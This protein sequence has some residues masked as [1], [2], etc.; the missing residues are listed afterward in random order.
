MNAAPRAVRISALAALLLAAAWLFWP[1]ALGG[2]TVYV[3][4]HGISMQPRFHTGDLAILRAADHY[5]VGD[6]VAYRSVTMKTTVMHRIV[7]MDGDRFVIQGDNNSWLDPDE[8]TPDLVLGKLWLRIPQ[9]GKALGL[10]NSPAALGLIAAAGIGVL[11]VMHKPR[12]RR[13]SRGKPRHRRVYT[14]S[15]RALAR[16]ITFASAGVALLAAA[17]G[18]ILLAMPP[19]QT[20]EKSVTVTQQ[21]RYDYTGT[22]VVG[23]TY[24]TGRIQTGD[25]IY[26]KLTGD[27]TVSLKDTLGGTDL[28]GLSGT[29]RLAVSI[30]APDGWTADVGRGATVPLVDGRT[31]TASAVVQSTAAAELLA[32]HYAEVGS[33]G[34]DATLTVTPQL[35]V[36]GTVAG[37]PFTAKTL[38]GLSF[39]LTA[40]SLRLAGTPGTALNPSVGTPVTVEQ[41]SPRHFTLLE[42][43]ISLSVARLAAAV[44][45]PLALAVVAVAWWIGRARTSDDPA[46]AFLMRNAAR[47]LPV[48]RFT[49]GTT[50]IDVS[51]ADALH[52]VAERLDTLVLHQ[53]GPDD[54]VFAVHDIETTYRFVLPVSHG[55]RPAPRRPD[56]PERPTI[57]LR[58]VVDDDETTRLRPV[59]DD[60]TARIS[61]V[62]RPRPVPPPRL[63]EPA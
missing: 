22:A 60:D 51:D 23:T 48:T 27:L 46:D 42:Q 58:P 39:G 43:T 19:T 12:D 11:G 21:G 10:I 50:V 57:R 56:V 8:P 25:P 37:R 33:G 61:R 7:A 24:P 3:T 52:R 9:G 20:D 15:T 54:H 13:R 28:S 44:V 6:V 41:T 47:I 1:L 36:S 18:G 32:R 5:S 26:T 55:G 31:A 63:P 29:L 40:T 16:Q 35:A 30:A 53:E 59:L 17:G 45:L 4:T 49:P 2:G 62:R 38:P 14:T 34:N